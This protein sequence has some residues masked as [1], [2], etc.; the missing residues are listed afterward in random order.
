MGNEPRSLVLFKVW[1][2]ERASFWDSR[3]PGIS[4][5]NAIWAT[6]FLQH[7]PI[8]GRSMSFWGE[9]FLLNYHLRGE[10][11]EVTLQQGCWC[12]WFFG[13]VARRSDVKRSGVKI[14]YHKLCTWKAW[15]IGT[16]K[17]LP[18]KTAWSTHHNK[19][20]PHLTLPVAMLPVKFPIYTYTH[21]R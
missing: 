16:S 21:A 10:F 12:R 11:G 8:Y 4:M 7:V 19:S 13:I 14:S 5:T 3:W 6:C 17:K 20:K 9:I 15:N 1:K 18:A 2:V